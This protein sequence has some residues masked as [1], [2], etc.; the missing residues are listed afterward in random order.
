VTDPI[1]DVGTITATWTDPTGTVWALSD[2]SDAV[3]WF[4]TPGPAGWHA[5]TYE[6]VSDPLSGGGEQVRFVRGK[7]GRITWPLYVWGD[8]HLQYVQRH[9]QIRRAFTMTAHRQL[10]GTLTVSRPD[11]TARAVDAFYQ[12]G[13]EGEAGE[14]WLWSKEAITLFCPDGYWRDTTPVS[15]TY[16]YEPGVDYLD[17][18]PSVSAG[19]SLGDTQMDN[20][21]DIEAWP[22]WTLTGPM[23][24]FSAT[25]VTLGYEFTLNYALAAGHQVTIVTDRTRPQVRSPTGDNLVSSLNWPTAYLWPLAAGVND[26]IFNVSGAE[27]GTQVQVEYYP[28]YEGA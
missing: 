2:T 18:F 5:T 11:S 20:T 25:N 15:L 24:A 21:G 17:P 8:T 7:S 12:A 6:I 3:G 19:L 16:S 1:T 23:A 10:A 27:P 22:T 9:R 4:T 13:L 28:R 26:V 14:G